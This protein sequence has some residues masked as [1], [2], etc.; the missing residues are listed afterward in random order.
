M[1]NNSIIIYTDKKSRIKLETH[2]EN[3]S[4][5]LTQEQIGRVFDTDRTSITKHIKNIFDIIPAGISPRL[6]RVV[7]LR[8]V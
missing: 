4:V 7:P 8:K 5:W 6:C 3:E 1:K 2:L